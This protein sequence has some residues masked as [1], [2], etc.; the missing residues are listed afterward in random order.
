MPDV[1]ELI[2]Q[3]HREVE[4]LFAG[5]ERSR[6]ADIASKICEDLDLHADAEEQVVY[7]VIAS[8]VPGGAEMVKEAK[9]EH[10]EARQLIGRIRRTSD[11][12]KLSE[13][14]SEL[15]QAVEHHVREEESDVLPKTRQALDSSRLNELGKAFQDA[16]A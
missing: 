16:K 3:D 7:P 10:R 14:V 11:H 13:L 6:D 15:R 12:D 2:E 5:F 4:S 8:D 1:V 9:G